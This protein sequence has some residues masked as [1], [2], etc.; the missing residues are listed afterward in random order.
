M[1]RFGRVATGTMLM[2]AALGMA[3]MPRPV[4]DPAIQP[5]DAASYEGSW[6][7]AL[8]TREATEGDTIVVSCARPIRIEAANATH[9]FYLGPDEVEAD[10]AIE[11]IATDDGA[12]W[13]P[14][15]GGPAY[16][17]VWVTEDSFYLYD[18]V[19]EGEPDWTAPYV[20][21]RCV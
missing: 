20:Y 13:K 3:P 10:A 5:D 7:L 18:A 4:A 6:S 19:A 2:L 15:A 11:L 1:T 17:A 14:I 8:P 9:I 12:D 21:T 16:F